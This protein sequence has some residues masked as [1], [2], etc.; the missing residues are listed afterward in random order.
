MFL[1]INMYRDLAEA[2]SMDRSWLVLALSSF[3][4]IVRGHAMTYMV[5]NTE[6]T[7][8][9]KTRTSHI[10]PLFFSP[11]WLILFVFLPIIAKQQ[12]NRHTDVMAVTHM[13]HVHN[14][15]GLN[16]DW[17]DRYSRCK[18]PVIFYRG[19]GW[20][21]SLLYR[22]QWSRSCSLLCTT[23]GLLEVSVWAVQ[24]SGAEVNRWSHPTKL[25]SGCTLRWSWWWGGYMPISPGLGHYKHCPCHETSI[26]VTTWTIEIVK[27]PLVSQTYVPYLQ[28]FSPS[29]HM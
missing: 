28:L 20:L 19:R 11:V 22:L 23:R 24:K 21:W 10:K 15:S 2:C 25:F 12:H 17:K 18:S 3:G 14:E 5:S 7:R 9:T 1:F 27:H 6:D 4:L 29:T 13:Y 26:I 8:Q 16:V